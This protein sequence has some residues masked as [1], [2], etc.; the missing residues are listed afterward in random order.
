MKKRKIIGLVAIFV[1]LCFGTGYY[2]YNYQNTKTF[3]YHEAK[4]D[5]TSRKLVNQFK[6][7]NNKQLIIVLYKKECP[8]CKEW[9][10]KITTVLDKKKAPTA[11]IE[12]SK[13]IPSYITSNIDDSYYNSAKAPYIMVL[14][15][16]SYKPVYAN[17]VDN[18]VELS[19]LDN[20][21]K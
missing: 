20:K 1:S 9:Q 16:K 15:N 14:E 13:G 17:R 21:V 8:V 3:T 4:Q 12:A 7:S 11:Y 6:K 18:E 10:S 2:F 19:K 5:E